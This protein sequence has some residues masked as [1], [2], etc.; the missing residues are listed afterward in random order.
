MPNVKAK[1]RI[2]VEID[3]G[4]W[5]GTSTFDE[6]ANRVRS[7]GTDLAQRLFN[8]NALERPAG[9]VVGPPRLLFVSLVEEVCR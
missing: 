9:R 3:V 2:E 1:I 5:D 8:P 6:I 4:V 7:E